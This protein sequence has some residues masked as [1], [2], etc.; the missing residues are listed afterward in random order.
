MGTTLNLAIYMLVKLKYQTYQTYIIKA[1]YR[2]L[3][4]ANG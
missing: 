1:T 3:N 4:F 2:K